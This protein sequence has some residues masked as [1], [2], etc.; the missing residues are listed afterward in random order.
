MLDLV[1][2]PIFRPF[3]FVNRLIFMKKRVIHVDTKIISKLEDAI[4]YRFELIADCF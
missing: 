2:L 1:Y 3:A 4:T